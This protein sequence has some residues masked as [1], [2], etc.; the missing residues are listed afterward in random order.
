MGNSNQSLTR[1][2]S[3]NKLDI[4]HQQDEEEDNSNVS[5]NDLNEP[6]YDNLTNK[7]KIFRERQRFGQVTAKISTLSSGNK[8]KEEE[9]SIHTITP[10]G[11]IITGSNCNPQYHIKEALAN[12]G[13]SEPPLEITLPD[14]RAHRVLVIH[15]DRW[16]VAPSQE[17]FSR[18]SG[19]CI[20]L[21]DKKSSSQP[22]EIKLG[23][24]FR[25]GSVGLVVAEVK[26]FNG[27]EQR[28][29]SKQLDF[30]IDEGIYFINFIIYYFNFN[31]FQFND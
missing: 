23:D 1:Q 14:S 16:Y 27:E 6:N 4:N 30:L 15:T 2:N 31:F 18:H 8:K 13:Y 24:C 9:Y 29:D 26:T 3:N 20:V 19:T 28:L 21:G 17:Y 12:Y 22:F 11:A 10:R 7:E 25:L 5:N